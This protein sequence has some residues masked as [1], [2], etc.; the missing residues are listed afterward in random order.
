MSV[1]WTVL[2][3]CSFLRRV[4]RNT[5]P[6]ASQTIVRDASDVCWFASG[7]AF[8]DLGNLAFA[9]RNDGLF[10]DVGD[11]LLEKARSLRLRFAK[12]EEV[13]E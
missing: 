10:C 7:D 1:S 8:E 4:I 11:E 6:F 2:F 5:G 9:E 3:A 12:D 13:E